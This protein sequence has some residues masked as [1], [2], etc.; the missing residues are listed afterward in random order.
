M[1]WKIYHK[2]H[3][4][5]KTVIEFQKFPPPKSRSFLSRSST[6][7]MVPLIPANLSPQDASAE[8]GV[9]ILKFTFVHNS[10][11]KCLSSNLNF[12]EVFLLLSAFFVDQSKENVIFWCLTINTQAWESVRSFGGFFPQRKIM[13]FYFPVLIACSWLIYLQ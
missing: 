2:Q 4:Y 9:T 10:D 13:V 5:I 1:L 12:S 7:K 6:T 3:R 8:W 11:R